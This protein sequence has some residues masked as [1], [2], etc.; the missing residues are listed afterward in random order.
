MAYDLSSF[1]TNT[2]SSNSLSKTIIDQLMADNRFSSVS[3]ITLNGTNYSSGNAN[4]D[5]IGY[6]E[7][8]RPIYES[9][10]G[11]TMNDE[12]K[13]AIEKKHARN[14][15]SMLKNIGSTVL[16]NTSTGNIAA[17]VSQGVIK[18]LITEDGHFTGKIKLEN[19]EDLNKLT[20]DT[21]RF[22]IKSEV[23]SLLS[24]K[25]AKSDLF[26]A[27]KKI[28]SEFI[29]KDI[30]RHTEFDPHFND[31][32]R[33]ITGTERGAWNNKYDKPATG[34]PMKDLDP[35]VSDRIK[36]SALNSDLSNHTNNLDIHTSSTERAK[37]NAKYDK[38]A[39]GIPMTDFSEIV[40]NSINSAAKAVDLQDHEDDVI[41]HI[42]G[43][44]RDKWNAKY[45]K[46]ANGVPMKDLEL[47]V[48]DKI[49]GAATA[50]A[51][52]DHK[53][54]SVAH[55]TNAERLSW[56]GKYVKPST[57]V[58]M[59]DLDSSVQSKIGSAAT[60]KELTDHAS[61][62]TVHISEKERENWNNHKADGTIHITETERSK[63]NVK[64]DK[65]STGIPETDL[66][67]GLQTKIN[68]MVTNADFLEH[69]TDSVRHL[70]QSERDKWN[71]K[72]DKPLTGIPEEDLEKDL[73]TKINS[74][75][76]SADL[77]AH[78]NDTVKHITTVERSNWN[79]KYVK[80][81][82]GIPE[83]D[84]TLAFRDK[85]AGMATQANL[86][87]HATDA[88]K[89]ITAD[90]RIAWNGKYAKPEEGIPAA[91]LEAG[92]EAKI[93]GSASAADLTTH[94]DNTTVHITAEE[95][96]IWNGKYAKPSTGIPESDMA[97][98]F[99]SKVNGMVSNTDFN[100]HATDTVKHVTA[101]ERASWNAKY[102]KPNTG[103]P[104]TDLS[105][106][107]KGK[108]DGA[109]SVADLSNHTG[110]TTV[111]IT[112]AERSKWNAK[113]DKPAEGIP[114]TD[115]ESG[116]VTTVDGFA[117]HVSDGTIHVTA[118][119]KTEWSAKYAKPDEGIPVTDLEA[120]VSTAL[121]NSANHIADETV[122]VTDEQ[123]TEWSAKYAKPDE[124][125][126]ATDLV[127]ELQNKLNSVSMPYTKTVTEEATT[128][129]ILATEHGITKEPFEY[130]VV[131]YTQN[132][133]FWETV[134]PSLVRVN[135]TTK[136]IEVQFP[137]AFIG[138]V[139]IR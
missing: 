98:S 41:K 96:T 51:L 9:S 105:D 94:V 66:A 102:A 5:P 60:K 87:A 1:Y 124:G 77:A 38:P 125:I 128:V 59:A 28:Y 112:D 13:D 106:A 12:L 104:E 3:K 131:A 119:Q 114:A 76:T 74:A 71:A 20:L 33:H 53:N 108:I 21:S 14:T 47:P 113:Y 22:Y 37:W 79:A 75:A 54:D 49:N 100:A 92:L 135:D 50:T 86:N 97:Q 23:D 78:A 138:K 57:G 67:S 127:V 19:I 17:F 10:V 8:G 55:I 65:P 73:K 36:A 103:I 88:V 25:I 46:P 44:E 95:R 82:D 72:Y 68:G 42:T 129:S 63:W 45:D 89:H 29:D 2:L 111:H 133:E 48:Q 91:D 30:V 101:S 137:T 35:V 16:E 123:K 39:T 27:D 7:T 122:H 90:E 61:N 64:Y 31:S 52:T 70:A 15:D 84:L 80:P 139:V 110:D 58:P 26:N 109:A 120:S 136:D 62:T 134:Q 6:T 85:V 32:V 121:T 34:I 83:T 40:Q 132:A 81:T 24:A 118:A 69:E 93:N 126:P 107:L 11:V 99:I 117:D 130:S 116:F 4:T 43:E 115:L 56:N 18:A